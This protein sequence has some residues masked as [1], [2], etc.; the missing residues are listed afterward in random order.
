MRRRAILTAAG[1]LAGG[2]LAAVMLWRKP[3]APPIAT[4]V[5]GN[6][7]G[8][9]RPFSTLV[10]VDP[11]RALADAPFTD[12]DGKPHHLAEFAGKGLVVN[13][14]ATWCAPCAAE[15]PALQDFA[16][17]AAG[18]G[19]LVL[20]LASD[21]GGA[22]AVQ[23]FYAGHGITALPI[24]L[25]PKAQAAEAWGVRGLPTTFIVDGQG[26]EVGSLEG[27]IDWSAEATLAGVRK[28]VA[29]RTPA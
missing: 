2:T 20:P 14:W 15:M 3:P 11:P 16:K 10:P 17:A 6:E 19:I 23:K 28:L 29:R 21:R 26:R 8:A 25:D 7:A 1:A 22:D 18:D 9:L 13:L 27:A 4:P 12:A 5:Q 24:W